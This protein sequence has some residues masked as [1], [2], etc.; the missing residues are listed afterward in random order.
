MAA[1]R[2]MPS[3]SRFL[4]SASEIRKLASYITLANEAFVSIKEEDLH[5]TFSD[6]VEGV[7]FNDQIEINDIS[8]TYPEAKIPALLGLSVKI[9]K[10]EFVGIV[11]A[12]GSGKSTF[13]KILSG[14]EFS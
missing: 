6:V 13:L 3:L 5:S 12:S 1:L 8:Y 2:I 4:M 9:R 14:L 11:G 10:G 7:R